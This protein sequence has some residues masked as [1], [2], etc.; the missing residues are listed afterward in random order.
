MS[1]LSNS[2]NNF[3][4]N[5]HTR[6]PRSNKKEETG[7]IDYGTFVELQGKEA[8][9]DDQ[10]EA[11]K[12]AFKTI[13]V[14][15]NCGFIKGKNIFLDVVSGLQVK[16][17]A[18]ARMILPRE[19]AAF[20]SNALSYEQFKDRNGSESAS[21][22]TEKEK[23]QFRTKVVEILKNSKPGLAK[24]IEMF[25]DKMCLLMGIEEQ[26]IAATV[27]PY[28]IEELDSGRMSYLDFRIRNTYYAFECMTD[29]EKDI[30]RQAF[31]NQVPQAFESKE[32]QIDRE[33]LLDMHSDF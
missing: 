28:E 24:G 3:S 18:L 31:I 5:Y 16:C 17:S 21:L 30:A 29:R 11:V 6:F 19:L 32:F 23:E 9:A 12:K 2:F 27:I 10:K 33:I 22:F 8:I 26:Q 1:R 15:E 14:S 7:E 13:F 4:E 20:K 25:G